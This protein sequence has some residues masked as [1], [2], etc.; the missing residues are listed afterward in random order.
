MNSDTV[1]LD[2]VWK[3]R[4]AAAATLGLCETQMSSC[5]PLGE[6]RRI[7]HVDRNVLAGSLNRPGMDADLR[8]IGRATVGMVR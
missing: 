7:D 2:E 6:H 8:A 5:R 1:T 4:N 3:L